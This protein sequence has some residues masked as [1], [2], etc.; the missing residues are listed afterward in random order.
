MKNLSNALLS[1]VALFILMAVLLQGGGKEAPSEIASPEQENGFQLREAKASIVR[2]VDG[3][4]VIVRFS[5]GDLKGKEER[6]RLLLI[7]TPE[8]VHPS[9][10]PEWLGKESSDYAKQY[11]KE[12]QKVTVEIGNPERDRYDRLLGYIWVDGVNFNQHMIEKGYARVAYVYP[13]NTKYLEEFE[14]AEEKA[15]K[16]KVGIWGV[17]GYVTEKG[18]DMSVIQ[19]KGEI[20]K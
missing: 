11:L 8:S 3:D 1:A 4:T 9:K 12:G 18:F 5:E 6:I 10:E 17:S 15:K 2:A 14:K 16:K 19:S 7:D 13:P 20:A